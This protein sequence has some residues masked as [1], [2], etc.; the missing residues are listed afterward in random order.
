MATFLFLHFIRA[1]ALQTAEGP[2]YPRLLLEDVLVAEMPLKGAPDAMKWNRTAE[3]IP[4]LIDHCNLQFPKRC[5]NCG[6]VYPDFRSFVRETSPVGMLAWDESHLEDIVG[7][8]SL[9]NCRCGSTIAIQCGDTG[10]GMYREFLAAIEEDAR[11]EGVEIDE[12][13]ADLRDEIRRMV[14]DS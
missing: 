3:F 10:G 1:L 6:R 12:L 9:A 11:S 2:R 14:L 13:L 4:H 8:L 5:A 7:T